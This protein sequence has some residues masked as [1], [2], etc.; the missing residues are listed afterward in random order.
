MARITGQITITIKIM[1][2]FQ[3]TYDLI[4]VPH[5]ATVELG[6]EKDC[7]YSCDGCAFNETP[8]RRLSKDDVIQTMSHLAAYWDKTGERSDEFQLI[9]DRIVEFLGIAGALNSFSREELKEM[10]EAS[11]DHGLAQIAFMCDAELDKRAI[12]D[13]FELHDELGLESRGVIALSLDSL[14]VDEATEGRKGKSNASWEMLEGED[15]YI[16]NPEKQSF[17]VF[18]TISKQNLSDIPEIARRALEAGAMLFIAP[19][20]THSDEMLAQTNIQGRLLMGNDTDILVTEEDREKMKEVITELE[21][22]KEEYPGAFLNVPATFDNML[23]ACKPVT[24]VFQSNCRERCKFVTRNG[25]HLNATPN[26][27]VVKKPGED[28]LSL[29]TCTC[30]IGITEYAKDNYANTR[31]SDLEL[32]GGDPEQVINMYRKLTLDLA[33][34]ACPGCNCRT[35][36]D[37]K[38][39]QGLK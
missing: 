37:I 28:D 22:L 11:Q 35:S 4:P 12:S 25:E 9:G 10:L 30:F 6:R 15:N 24:E 21:K 14:P 36:I 39:G 23:A 34:T 17:R 16:Q 3:G 1:E 31:L 13:F 27:R 33:E 20:T 26:I 18:T 38:R 32:M 29:A 2:D 8:L 19:L 7:P 5:A